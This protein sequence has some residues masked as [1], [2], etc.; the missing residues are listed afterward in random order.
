MDV[1]GLGLGWGFW[2]GVGFVLVNS[3]CKFRGTDVKFLP[4][5]LGRM[6]KFGFYYSHFSSVLCFHLVNRSPQLSTF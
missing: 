4:V 6:F 3:F 2:F 5:F 1:S